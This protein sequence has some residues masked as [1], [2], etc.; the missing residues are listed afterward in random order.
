MVT[1]RAGVD[2][3]ME[4]VFRALADPSRRLLL[5]R[6]FDQDGQTLGQLCRARPD[7]TRFGVMKHLDVLAD[8]GLVTTRRHGR[9]KL[10]YLNPVPIRLV[11]DRW[12]SKYAEPFLRAITRLKADLEAPT[13][14]PRTGEEPMTE[15]RTMTRPAFVHEV[16]IRTTA[17]RL[18]QAL[19]DPM[20]TERYYYGG[21]VHCDDWRAGQPYAYLGPGD[22]EL[23]KGEVVE[24][25]A[26]QRLVMSFSAL[27]D[28]GLAGDPPSRLTFE[29]TPAGETC[30]LTVV[31]DGFEAETATLREVR[32]GWPWIVSG[33]KSLLET[34][35][36]LPAS[37][38]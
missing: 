17:E 18:W 35:E 26:P 10:H 3:G 16:F 36:A 8:A 33:L 22:V 7:M 9:E 24:A 28:P 1:Y 27:W 12:I 19:T 31:H 20:M 15:P 25:D 21:R 32:G 4:G 38:S 2:P 34:G 14:R 37:S 5:D 29:I 13:T 23:I 6:L 11:H 30:K